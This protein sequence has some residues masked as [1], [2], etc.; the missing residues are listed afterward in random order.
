MARLHPQGGA[1]QKAR[2]PESL[3]SLGW[4][5]PAQGPP[6]QR[7]SWP[8]PPRSSCTFQT[9]LATLR[10]GRSHTWPF[11]CLS[12]VIRKWAAL[13]HVCPKPQS[14]R[15]VLWV[16]YG[17]PWVQ[18]SW[19]D[20]P[21]TGSAWPA[22]PVAAAP[23]WECSSSCTA[24]IGEV[25]LEIETVWVP[26]QPPGSSSS[27]LFPVAISLFLPVC[28][29]TSCLRNHFLF[30]G[31]GDWTLRFSAKHLMIFTLLCGS[32]LY[33]KFWIW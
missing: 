31:H 20:A 24:R 26:A 5:R 30:Q 33:S 9:N 23:G 12:S 21:Q 11:P 3:S 32:S 10:S 14:A 6:A 18:G 22:G 25:G 17:P 4:G 7:C 27:L 29:L 15:C 8:P 28:V 2:G 1:G 16:K 19:T 13:T